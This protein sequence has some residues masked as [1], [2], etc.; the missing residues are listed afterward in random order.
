MLN[1][2]AALCTINRIGLSLALCTILTLAQGTGQT[3]IEQPAW[4]WFFDKA[5]VHGCFLL[6]NLNSDSMKVYNTGRMDS[7]FVPASTFK[8]PNSLFALEAG[9]INVD[10]TLRWDGVQRPMP[11]WNGDQ[12]MRSAFSYSTVWYY[13]EMARRIGPEQMRHFLDTLGYGNGSMEGGIDRFWLEGGMRITPREQIAFLRR[14][15]LNN[16]PFTQ[17]VI[18]LVKEIMVVERTEHYV[19]RAKTGRGGEGRPETGWYVGYVETLGQTYIFAL[20]IDVW[21]QEDTRARID[22][23]RRILHAESIIDKP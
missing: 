21:K 23:T 18:D 7:G 15:V 6:Y 3:V 19:L 10:D 13:Q 16:V 22:V 12:N 11:R 2:P 4:K 5:T 8:I 9:V 17:K 1:A 20:N 14:F